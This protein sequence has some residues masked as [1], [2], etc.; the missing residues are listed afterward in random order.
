MRKGGSGRVRVE[1]AGGGAGRVLEGDGA[2]EREGGRLEEEEAVRLQPAHG[3]EL[4]VGADGEA[5]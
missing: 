2:Q 4:I 1:G 3:E 5:R